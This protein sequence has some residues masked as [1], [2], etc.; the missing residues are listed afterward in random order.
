MGNKRKSPQEKKQLEF[1][2]DHF[3]GGYNSAR[4][5]SKGWRRKKARV[6]REYRRK[7]DELLAPIKP[8]LEADD[9]EMIS[10][11]LTT[12]HFQK[13]VSRKRLR[14]I[15]VISIGERVKERLEH[16]SKTVSRRVHQ[17]QFDD[18]VA[19]TA[20]RT[21]S[22]LS[23]KELIEVVNEAKLVRKHDGIELG[24]IRN[25]SDPVDQALSFLHAVSL[26]SG[27]ELEALRR[28]PDVNR[29][30][31]RWIQKVDRIIARDRRKEER[32]LNEKEAVRQKTRIVVRRSKS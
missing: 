20:V 26:G 6:N 5:F 10:G 18:R 32:K 14:K 9:A 11:E 22:Q 21:L 8:G 29:D 15:G 30:L 12:A 23:G 4:G 24:R 17:H 19:K 1:T 3:S 28:N 13:S 27:R 31:G 2:R 25:S 16:R 7:S